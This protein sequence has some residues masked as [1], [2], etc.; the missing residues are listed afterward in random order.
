MQVS[1]GEGVGIRTDPESC[2]GVREGEGEAPEGFH[3][4]GQVGVRGWR[5]HKVF[6]GGAD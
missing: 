4:K 6:R 5:G 1:Y 3:L 2:V